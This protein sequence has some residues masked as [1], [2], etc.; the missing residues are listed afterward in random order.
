MGLFLGRIGT[1]AIA[2]N[3]LF[4]HYRYDGCFGDLGAPVIPTL[5]GASRDVVTGYAN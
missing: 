5:R 1:G 3:A 2:L 4:R